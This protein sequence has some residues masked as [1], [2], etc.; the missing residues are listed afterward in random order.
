MTTPQIKE[1]WFTQKFSWLKRGALAAFICAIIGVP[2]MLIKIQALAVFG[3]IIFFIGMFWLFG[4]L[5]I[6][7]VLHWKDRYRGE[8]S[9]LWA[10]VLVIETSGWFKII[11]WFRHILPD[12]KGSG[13]YAAD[14]D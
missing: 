7:P 8:K 13:R 4:L 5:T 2:L 9:T 6:L 12:R 14:G 3:G 10:I 1:E 11:Y